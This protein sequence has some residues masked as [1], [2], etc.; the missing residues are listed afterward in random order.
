MKNVV[1]ERSIKKEELDDIKTEFKKK[2][3][4]KEGEVWD[5]KLEGSGYS[6]LL[7]S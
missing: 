3:L 6:S 7:I 5:E 2:Y 4:L 1:L